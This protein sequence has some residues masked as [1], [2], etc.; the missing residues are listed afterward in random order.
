MITLR[1]TGETISDD[2][3]INIESVIVVVVVV[4]NVVRI[5]NVQGC[6]VFYERV[7]SI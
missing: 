6:S 3:S 4:V 7:S 2:F 5:T 1:E